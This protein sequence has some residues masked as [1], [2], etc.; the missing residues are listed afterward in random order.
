MIIL[1][2]FDPVAMRIGSLAVRWYGLMYVFGFTAAWLLG[3]RRASMPWTKLDRPMFQ[4]LLFWILL[5]LMLGARLGYAL[6][7]NFSYYATR[8][9]EIMAF[10]QGGMSFHGGLIGVVCAILLFSWRRGLHPLDTGD[11]IAP[12]VPPGLFFGRLGNFIN[13]ELWGRPSD[14]PWAMVFP[15]QA[16]GGLPRHPSQLYEAC[17]EGIVLFSALWLYSRR[18]RPR[19]AVGG[20]F[21]LL[22]GSFRFLVEFTRQ[23]DAQLGFVALGWLSMGQVLSLPMIAIGAWLLLRNGG[24]EARAGGKLA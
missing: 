10:W 9:L 17:L 2:E 21:L 24:K 20:L 11:F 23:P 13:S 16:S 5:G 1:P 7:Y 3:N 12:L 22:Y 15:N 6:F 18:P 14:L 19:G 4:D 8:P